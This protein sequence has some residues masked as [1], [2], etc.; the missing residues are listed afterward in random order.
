MAYSGK[1][2]QAAISRVHCLFVLSLPLIIKVSDLQPKSSSPFEVKCRA[3]DARA[4][5]AL[6]VVIT[7]TA[8]TQKRRLPYLASVK[9]VKRLCRVAYC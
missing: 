8:R 9:K 4:V 2:L 6:A 3:S 1:K 5:V 7:T